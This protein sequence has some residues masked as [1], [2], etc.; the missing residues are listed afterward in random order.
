LEYSVSRR[1]KIICKFPVGKR[2]RSLKGPSHQ[3][4]NAQT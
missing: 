3:I 4:R 2:N 1:E